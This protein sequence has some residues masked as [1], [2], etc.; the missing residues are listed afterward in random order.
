MTLPRAF[1]SKP[2][3][4]VDSSE[5]VAIAAIPGRRLDRMIQ[6]TH[7]TGDASPCRSS[8]TTVAI[9]AAHPPATATACTSPA[10]HYHRLHVARKSLPPPAPLAKA[11]PSCRQQHWHVGVGMVRSQQTTPATDVV[12]IDGAAIATVTSPAAMRREKKEQ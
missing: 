12:C 8:S 9:D 5:V 7:L 10:S 1:S 3:L 11:A 2:H 6:A 4:A